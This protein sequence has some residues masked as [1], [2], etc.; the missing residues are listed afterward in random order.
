MRTSL[1]LFLLTALTQPLHAAAPQWKN[2]CVGYYQLQLPASITPDVFPAGNFINPPLF[3]ATYGRYQSGVV[4]KRAMPASLQAYRHKIQTRTAFSPPDRSLIGEYPQAFALY[5]QDRHTVYIN[6]G[7][8][9]YHFWHEDLTVPSR[10][11]EQQRRN[12]EAQVTLLNTRFRPRALFEV[13]VASGFC[14][15]FGFIANDSGREPHNVAAT[16]RLRQHPQV[17]VH[18]QTL[19][20]PSDTVLSGQLTDKEKIT[21]LWARRYQRPPVA[22]TV[23]EPQWRVARMAGRYGL[24][25]FIESTFIDGSRG[26]DYIAFV[27]GDALAPGETPDLLL[28]V[29]LD[30]RRG[31]KKALM[32]Q[33]ALEALADKIAASVQR[34]E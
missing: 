29:T 20:L 16:W 18:F 4:S 28:H 27:P 1:W 8:R 13:P 23:I 10:S 2:E 3:D 9:W 33:E 34:R 7:K 19:G 5:E 25:T 14:L 22:K 32:T 12:N 17:S 30:S 31:A 15:P 6:R 21:R 26:Y 24:S 11:A